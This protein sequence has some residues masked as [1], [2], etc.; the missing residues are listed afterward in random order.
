MFLLKPDASSLRQILEATDPNFLLHMQV[1][2]SVHT[3]CNMFA[4]KLLQHQPQ[5]LVL[6]AVTHVKAGQTPIDENALDVCIAPLDSVNLPI[7]DL[8]FDSILRRRSGDE[9]YQPKLRPH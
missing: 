1:R 2:R 6:Q 3:T 4:N 7:Y 8:D 9:I 5:Q